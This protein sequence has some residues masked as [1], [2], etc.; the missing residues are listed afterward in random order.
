MSVG[1]AGKGGV[2]VYKFLPST[3][4]VPHGTTVTFQMSAKT[5]EDHT[6]TTGP[7]AATAE[8]DPSTYI[9]KLAA[10]FTAPTIDPSG[11]YP[12]DPP[13]GPATFGADSH[14]NGFWNSGVMDVVAASPLPNAAKVT[15][16]TPGPTRSLPDPPLHA[17]DRRR[18]V[19]RRTRR[20]AVRPRSGP[21]RPL[22]PRRRRRGS[23]GSRPSTS[24]GT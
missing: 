19:R 20:H 11:V 24:T 2:E 16:G 4:T 18:H 8:T 14:G 9:G 21:R 15:F 23:T 5:Y 10:S 22:R 12:S 6:A 7:G 3:L 13:P 1:N 17:R